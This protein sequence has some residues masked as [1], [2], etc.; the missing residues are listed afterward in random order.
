MSLLIIH[1]IFESIDIFGIPV[2]LKFKNKEIFKTLIG[3]I[4]SILLILIIIILFI[5]NI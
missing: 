2:S 1:K 5:L 3:G 4:A